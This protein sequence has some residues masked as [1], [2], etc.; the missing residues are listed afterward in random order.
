M[1]HIND[2]FLRGLFHAL[3]LAQHLQTLHI[4]SHPA[5]LAASTAYPVVFSPPPHRE[6]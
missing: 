6:S 4:Y 5:A 2:I 1:P 3:I